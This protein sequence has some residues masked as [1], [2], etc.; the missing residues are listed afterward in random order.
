M[1][2][3]M[4]LLMEKDGM[5]V[6]VDIGPMWTD[7]TL[8]M[9]DNDELVAI[10]TSSGE[11]ENDLGE[12]MLDRNTLQ[13]ER[14]TKATEIMNTIADKDS[15]EEFE[16]P[17]WTKFELKEEYLNKLKGIDKNAPIYI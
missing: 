1:K 11:Y 8:Y 9:K 14:L 16:R 13:D 15:I 7:P 17:N 6:Y 12:F 3:K 5:K 2:R 4:D 10:T